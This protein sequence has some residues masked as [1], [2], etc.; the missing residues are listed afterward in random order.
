MSDKGGGFEK[1]IALTIVAGAI[2]GAVALIISVLAIPAFIAFLAFVGWKIYEIRTTSTAAL[3]R[4]AQARTEALY[5]VALAYEAPDKIEFGKGVYSLLCDGP[6]EVEDAALEAALDMFDVEGWGM[7]VPSPPPVANSIEGARYRDRLSAL[8]AMT[9]HDI[10]AI[11]RAIAKSMN[12]VLELAP[13]ERDGEPFITQPIHTFV[14]DL[15]G[16]VESVAL[17]YFASD[18]RNHFTQLRERLDQNM[19]AQEVMPSEYR[20]DDVV[21]AYLRSTPLYNLFQAPIAVTVPRHI[22]HEHTVITGGTGHGKTTLIENLILRDLKDPAQPSIVVIDSQRALIGKLSKLADAHRRPLIVIDPKDAPA[23]NVF[24]LNASR[25]QSYDDVGR[26]RVR[27]HTIDLFAYL[28]DSLLG[29]DLTTRQTALFGYLIQVMLAMP[30]AMGRNATLADIVTFTEHPDDYAPA[31]DALQDTAKTFFAT[32][33]LRARYSETKEQIRYRLHAILGN[34]TIARLFLAEENKVDFFEELNRGAIVLIDTDKGF[35]GSKN[36]AY[37][38]RI[39]I[40]LILQAILERDASEAPQREVFM[41]VDEAGEYF[42]RSIDKFLTEARK[43]RAGITLAHQ[44]FGQMTSELRASI[45]TNTATKY[46]GGLS[47]QDA[48]SAAQDMRASPDFLLDQERLSFACYIRNVTKTPTSVT[49]EIG[50]LEKEP[51]VSGDVLRTFRERNRARLA[52]SPAKPAEPSTP[53]PPHEASATGPKANEPPPQPSHPPRQEPPKPSTTGN[54]K[55]KKKKKA[56]L[57][58]DPSEYA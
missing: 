51:Q 55:G 41:Y 37:L 28:F 35:L 3:E 50:V 34:S 10:R 25:L 7:G 32:D 22:R 30:E 49:A 17:P 23:L 12:V 19:R 33:F 47:A 6:Q 24:S 46:A 52:A 2:A 11:Q 43:Q 18:V 42:D 58:T 31:I 38:G 9:E 27:N 4:Q 15:N 36:S 44:H 53:P 54:A 1:L 45:A 26:E 57:S 40:T 56:K 48:R 13:D 20:G 16:A 29:A 21:L 14:A 39:A 5:Q 8:T